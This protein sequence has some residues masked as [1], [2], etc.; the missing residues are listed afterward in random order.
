MNSGLYVPEPGLLAT[1]THDAV[2]MALEAMQQSDVATALASQSYD[3][4]NGRRRFEDGYWVDAPIH[5][6]RYTDGGKLV[7]R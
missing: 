3:G 6:Y 4:L 2:G 5:Y 7:T 1:L